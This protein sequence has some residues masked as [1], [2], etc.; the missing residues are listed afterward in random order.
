MIF[1]G[2]GGTYVQCFSQEYRDY[3]INPKNLNF[4][5]TIVER[6]MLPELCALLGVEWTKRLLY[7][8]AIIMKYKEDYFQ[9]WGA[10]LGDLNKKG[11]Y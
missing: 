6:S 9:V 7:G 3:D 4:G 1:S 8:Y 10:Q 2:N 11:F 5:K